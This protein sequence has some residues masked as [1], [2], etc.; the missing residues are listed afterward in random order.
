MIKEARVAVIFKGSPRLTY[1]LEGSN[2]LKCKVIGIT[3][4]V[5]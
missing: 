5:P 2:V 4:D 1:E 3:L